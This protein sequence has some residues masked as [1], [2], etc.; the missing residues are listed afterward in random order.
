M[1]N[2]KKA[3][4]GGV[5]RNDDLIVWVTV[6]RLP[7]GFENANDLEVNPFDFDFFAYGYSASKQ[8]FGHGSPKDTNFAIDLI[9]V[10]AEESTFLEAKTTHFEVAIRSAKNCGVGIFVEVLNLLRFTCFR[11][12]GLNVG[13][14]ALDG[15]SIRSG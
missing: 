8:V 14:L 11:G 2:S 5:K 6:T 7:F 9:V 1:P 12:D 13:K 15:T 10:T 3:F 4:L